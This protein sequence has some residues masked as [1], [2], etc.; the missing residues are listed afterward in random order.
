MLDGAASWER[1]SPDPSI[2]LSP[3]T[4]ERLAAALATGRLEL[5]GDAAVVAVEETEGGYAPQGDDGKR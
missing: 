2:A 3:H 1:A 4:R 5:L